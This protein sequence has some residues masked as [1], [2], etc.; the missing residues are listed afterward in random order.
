[1]RGLLL[2]QARITLLDAGSVSEFRFVLPTCC[3]R[4]HLR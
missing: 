1:M 3:G 2:S 4:I